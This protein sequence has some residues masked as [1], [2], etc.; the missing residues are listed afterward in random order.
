MSISF[1]ALDI[2]FDKGCIFC[3]ISSYPNF[4]LGDVNIIDEIESWNTVKVLITT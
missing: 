2:E 1:I 3:S 4:R